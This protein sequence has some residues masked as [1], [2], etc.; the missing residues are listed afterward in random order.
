MP[1]LVVISIIGYQSLISKHSMKWF[2]VFCALLLVSGAQIK[3]Q[4]SAAVSRM[5]SIYSAE[6][7]ADMQQ[8]DLS[9]YQGLVWWFSDSWRITEDGITRKPSEAE[10]AAIDI[11]QYDSQRSYDQVVTINH[12][13]T[14][15][16]IELLSKDEA[17]QAVKVFMTSEKWQMTWD[18]YQRVRAG[19]IQHA[20]KSTN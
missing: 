4:S 20:A 2:G 11:R 12:E 3:G 19:A 6:Q 16:Q 5:Q 7:I 13:A 15:Q 17:I 1:T 18:Q 9:K 14:G 10:I 8:N